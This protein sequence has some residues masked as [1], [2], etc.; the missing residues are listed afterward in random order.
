[1][2]GEVRSKKFDRA[3][4][5]RDVRLGGHFHPRGIETGMFAEHLLNNRLQMRRLGATEEF[6]TLTKQTKISLCEQVRVN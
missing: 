3:S 1:M 6:V 5:V 2:N 4:V